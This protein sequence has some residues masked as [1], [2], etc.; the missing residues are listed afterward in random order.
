[1]L[2]LLLPLGVL[3]GL[4]Q[5]GRSFSDFALILVVTGLALIMSSGL[6]L[7][8]L[9]RRRL[10]LASCLVSTSAWRQR[11]RGGWVLWLLAFLRALP[12]ALIL[13]VAV[14]RA[15]AHDP[16]VMLL[17]VNVPV[18]V[19]MRHFWQNRLAGDVLSTY[20]PIIAGRLAMHANLGVLLLM[21]LVFAF[22]T[23]YPDFAEVGLRD[24]ILHEAG[25]QHAESGFLLA[26]MQLAAAKDAL[27]WW[28][29][30]Q[31]LP[32]TV[33]PALQLIGWT[34]LLATDVVVVWSY[35]VLCSATLDLTRR[36]VLPP[37]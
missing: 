19:L 36:Q 16:L 20:L 32:G 26:A 34:L 21:L 24:A 22:N 17:I 30:Q 31:F 27:S 10:F 23:T 18:L 5:V 14:Q 29:G 28:L 9:S 3:V 12:L 11:L 33:Q 15:D 6:W 25:R 8:A 37:M 13:S 1:M 4:G 35:L 2:V 7:H